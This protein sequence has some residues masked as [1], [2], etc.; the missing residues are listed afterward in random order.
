MRAIFGAFSDICYLDI[1]QGNLVIH[2]CFFGENKAILG[3]FSDLYLL[4]R[5][6]SRQ[7]SKFP[8]LLNQN[9]W[10][11]KCTPRAFQNGH[12][13]IVSHVTEGKPSTAIK[14]FI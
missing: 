9:I 2:A 13:D 4:F 12:L 6:V 7:F 10:D 14:W 5:H 1:F 8:E 3:L 11:F